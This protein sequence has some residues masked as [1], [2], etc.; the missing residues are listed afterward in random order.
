M[1]DTHLIRF[2]TAT[3]LDAAAQASLNLPIYAAWN[4]LASYIHPHNQA[5]AAERLAQ[6]LAP[7]W[8]EYL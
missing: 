5:A 4:A 2:N 6:A 1:N 7:N 3:I 8:K